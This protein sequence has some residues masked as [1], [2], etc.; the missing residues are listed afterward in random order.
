VKG[1]DKDKRCGICRVDSNHWFVA[2]SC[3]M[4]EEEEM[5]LTL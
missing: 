5:L 1:T 4:E 3:K 2:E